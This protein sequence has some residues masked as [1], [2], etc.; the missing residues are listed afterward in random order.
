MAVSWQ[1]HEHFM[2]F[3]V[4][5]MTLFH[6]RFTPAT[7]PF[8]DRFM[9]VSRPF[10]DDRCTAFHCSFTTYIL[11]GRYLDVSDVSNVAFISAAGNDPYPAAASGRNAPWRVPRKSRTWTN[12]AAAANK[13]LTFSMACTPMEWPK[14]T[15]LVGVEPAAR[16][17]PASPHCSAA[18]STAALSHAVAV[19]VKGGT[20]SP[21]LSHPSDAARKA[22]KTHNAGDDSQ[23]LSQ[24]RTLLL[25]LATQKA[26][27]SRRTSL[28]LREYLSQKVLRRIRTLQSRMK[29]SGGGSF[30][31]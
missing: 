25:N 16:Q 8:H 7:G 24:R 12:A 27:A 26:N 29:Q 28:S 19:V 2:A 4:H 11:H 5:Y 14:S 31:A 30:Q 3:C 13:N 21:I 20:I 23:F 10:H 18:A 1:F 15:H 9:A 6:D 17:L 22:S